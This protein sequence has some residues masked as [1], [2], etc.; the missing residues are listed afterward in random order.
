MRISIVTEDGQK[1][2]RNLYLYIKLILLIN[3]LR[4]NYRADSH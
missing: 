2:G 1:V 3:N 4:T